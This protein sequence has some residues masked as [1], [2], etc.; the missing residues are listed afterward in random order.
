MKWLFT[1]QVRDTLL[2]IV[3]PYRD[4]KLQ[5][6]NS[7][8]M[9]VDERTA[10]K[11]Y[12]SSESQLPTTANSKSATLGRTK[13]L[14]SAAHLRHYQQHTTAPPS[15]PLQQ[16]KVDRLVKKLLKAGIDGDLGMVKFLLHW[17]QPSGTTATSKERSVTCHPLCECDSCIKN[18]RINCAMWFVCP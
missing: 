18:V 16:S 11:S 3:S 8:T 13:S 14:S 12:H 2:S 6:L 7:H 17:N 1:Q 5:T 15:S 10:S 9:S 4:R